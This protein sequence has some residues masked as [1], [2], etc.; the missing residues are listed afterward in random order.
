M[1]PRRRPELNPFLHRR[2]YPHEIFW[3]ERRFCLG[4]T[5]SSARAQA[6]K[7]RSTPR[8]HELGAIGTKPMGAQGSPVVQEGVQN[9]APPAT[10]KTGANWSVTAYGI[11]VWIRN[12]T[13]LSIHFSTS[14]C[15]F[16]DT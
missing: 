7:R 12:L 6:G 10:R 3:R 15:D 4:E 11:A 16:S 2:R 9:S 1:V 8:M 14:L 5:L 13:S